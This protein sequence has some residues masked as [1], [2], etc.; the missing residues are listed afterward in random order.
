MVARPVRSTS[1]PAQTDPHEAELAMANAVPNDAV[2]VL[3]V[4]S[5]ALSDLPANIG[6]WLTDLQMWTLLLPALCLL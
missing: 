1:R 6:Q 2:N 3:A 5:C 4:C